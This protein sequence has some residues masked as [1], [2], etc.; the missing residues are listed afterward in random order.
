MMMKRQ[1]PNRQVPPSRYYR[2]GYIPSGLLRPE[3]SQALEVLGAQ[4]HFVV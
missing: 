3:V 1:D 2:L 4:M